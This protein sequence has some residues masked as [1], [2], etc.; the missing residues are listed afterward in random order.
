MGSG[1]FCGS[2]RC[3]PACGADLCGCRIPALWPTEQ[4][5]ALATDIAAAQGCNRPLLTGWGYHEL[6]LVWR[7]GKDTRLFPASAPEAEVIHPGAC[8]VVIRARDSA[9]APLALV[10][11]CRSARTVSG[12]AIGA[13]RNVTLDVL[14]C[15]GDP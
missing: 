10:K 11:G 8:V 15:R 2:F 7:G 14:D 6:S 13:G 5:V 9:T 12:L 4:A 3:H 1:G